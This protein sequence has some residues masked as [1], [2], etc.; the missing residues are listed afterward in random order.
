M[1]AADCAKR[2]N[3]KFCVGCGFQ[4]TATLDFTHL[5]WRNQSGVTVMNKAAIYIRVS[6]EG[7]G[8]WS[9]RK[10]TTRIR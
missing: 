1:E 7:T 5:F 4:S 10:R 3:E 8:D 6:N 9:V 2:R